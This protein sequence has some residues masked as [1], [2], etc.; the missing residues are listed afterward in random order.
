VEAFLPLK[1]GLQVYPICETE[2][3]FRGAIIPGT[4]FVFSKVGSFLFLIVRLVL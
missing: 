2:K 1:A 3:V 4:S